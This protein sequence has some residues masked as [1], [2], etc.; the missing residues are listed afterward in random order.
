MSVLSDQQKRECVD[1]QIQLYV[2]ELDREHSRL[3]SL[4][5]MQAKDQFMAEVTH[6]NSSCYDRV[7]FEAKNKIE[8][9]TNELHVW[10]N[11]KEE[12]KELWE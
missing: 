11:W 5:L 9:I 12:H 1:E 8:A 4:L 7:I 6:T 2:G 10:E 3:E